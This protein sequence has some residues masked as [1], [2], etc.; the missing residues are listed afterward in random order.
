MEAANQTLNA[1]QIKAK[2]DRQGKQIMEERVK[3]YNK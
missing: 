1:F 2:G 3:G